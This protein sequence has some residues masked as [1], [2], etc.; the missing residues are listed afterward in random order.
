M[1][2]TETDRIDLMYFAAEEAANRPYVLSEEQRRL[3]HQ[4]E[5]L[6]ADDHVLQHGIGR[7]SRLIGQI[8][9]LEPSRAE[10]DRLAADLADVKSQ[11]GDLTT[12]ATKAFENYRRLA[13]DIVSKRR[14]KERELNELDAQLRAVGKARLTP[15]GWGAAT[16]AVVFALTLAGIMFYLLF[17]L[18]GKAPEAKLEVSYNIA[19]MVQALLVGAGALV[20][21]IAYALSTLRPQNG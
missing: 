3:L 8:V 10:R 6:L 5:Q 12:D 11:L 1:P 14:T 20:A 13:D 21:G 2:M 16:L 17:T 9:H 15:R 7:F 19:E 18:W 4:N